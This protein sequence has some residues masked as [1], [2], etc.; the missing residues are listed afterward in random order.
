MRPGSA[1]NVSQIDGARPSSPVAPSIW[2]ADVETPHMKPS[3]IAETP[4]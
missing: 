1:A 2:Y 3:G 4:W